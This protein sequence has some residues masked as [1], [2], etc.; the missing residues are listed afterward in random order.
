MQVC[1]VTAGPTVWC[2]DYDD[3]NNNNNNNTEVVKIYTY[4]QGCL[5][6]ISA[7]SLV[8]LTVVYGFPQFLQS[9][10]GIL[11]YYYYAYFINS[12]FSPSFLTWPPIELL[13]DMLLLT[14]CTHLV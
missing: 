8:F 3:D 4:I 7:Q 1:S 10:S 5:F 2:G 11:C 13:L 9:N 6:R 14:F 12:N